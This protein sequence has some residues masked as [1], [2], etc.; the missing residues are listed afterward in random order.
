MCVTMRSNDLWY[1]FCNDQYCFSQLQ[2]MIAERLSIDVGE[3]YHFAHNMHIYW[4]NLGKDKPNEES[5][6]QKRSEHYK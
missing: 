3:Y 4:K 5:F 6:L 1:G 2:K